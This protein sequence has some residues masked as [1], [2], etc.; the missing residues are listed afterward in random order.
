MNELETSL[1]DRSFINDQPLYL[2]LFMSISWRFSVSLNLIILW[3]INRHRVK[4]FFLL[5][6]FSAGQL[7]LRDGE[8]KTGF[9]CLLLVSGCA[10]K[11][12]L[13]GW[14]LLNR[15]FLSPFFF[16]NIFNKCVIYLPELIQ[17]IE[18]KIVKMKFLSL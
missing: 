12:Y 4:S 3:V 16:P 9:L 11:W 18:Y 13:F 2:K 1:R 15:W 14:P 10:K 8:P 5:P 6:G 7:F 17:G